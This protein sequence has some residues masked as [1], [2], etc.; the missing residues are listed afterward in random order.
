M[1]DFIPNSFQVPNALVDEI[2][3]T[4]NPNSLKCYLIVIRKTVGWQKEWDKISTTQLMELSGI[5]RKDT[6]YNCM[7]ELEG[8]GLIESIKEQ[9]KLTKYRL[10]LKNRTGTDKPSQTSTE[11]PYPTKDNNKTQSKYDL[12]LS[13]LKKN[14]KYKTKVTKTKE[15]KKLFD[16]IEDKHQLV[17]DYIQHQ[18]D[19][20]SFSVRITAFMEDYETVYK[21]EQED[22]YQEVIL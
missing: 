13:Y 11:K 10:V 8:L 7:K 21:L 2:I 15:G 19:K 9:G 12:F 18:K 20:E 4:L 1:N 16:S 17:K 22:R 3:A 5:K 6:V 14:C